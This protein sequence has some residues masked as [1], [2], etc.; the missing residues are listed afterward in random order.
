MS[1]YPPTYDSVEPRYLLN[2]PNLAWIV[3]NRTAVTNVNNTIR[4]QSGGNFRAMIG[5][6]FYKG[7]WYVSKVFYY[8]LLGLYLSE[9]KA[10]VDFLHDVPF[11]VLTCQPYIRKCPLRE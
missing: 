7:F 10:T 1:G 4:M 3:T 11:Q 5:R 2:H 8:G 9:Y 6:V